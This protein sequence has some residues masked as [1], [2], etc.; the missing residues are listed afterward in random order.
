MGLACLGEM[1]IRERPRLGW[2]GWDGSDA[3]KSAEL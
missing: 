3:E 1:K 2:V